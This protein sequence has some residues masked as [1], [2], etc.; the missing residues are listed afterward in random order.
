MVTCKTCGNRWP[1]EEYDLE[2]VSSNESESS[3][4]CPACGGAGTEEAQ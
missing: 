2:I 1:L 4:I 3:Y